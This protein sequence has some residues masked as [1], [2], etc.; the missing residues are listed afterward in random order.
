MADVIKLKVT[1]NETII[2]AKVDNVEEV[3]KEIVVPLPSEDVDKILNR[4]VTEISTQAEEL[5]IYALAHCESLT[6]IEGNNVKILQDSSLYQCTSLTDINFPKLQILRANSLRGCPLKKNMIFPELI[7][8]EA[9]YFFDS[10]IETLIT[11]KLTSIAGY[12]FN[13][14][15]IKQFEAPLLENL[16]SYFMYGATKMIKAVFPN[17]TRVG[18]YAFSDCGATLIDLGSPTQIGSYAFNSVKGDVY[19]RTPTV[20]KMTGYTTNFK[21]RFFVPQE[22]VDQYKVAD[23]WSD[24]AD[25]IFAIEEE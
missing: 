10:K 21:G 5:G 1:D 23:Y 20:C 12:N 24:W 6:S 19:I 16:P 18:N 25:Q 3:I 22:L 9:V 11:P 4:S 7:T 15:N 13:R 14:S 8:M 17:C 2:K